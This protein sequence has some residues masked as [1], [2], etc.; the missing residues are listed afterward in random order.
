[1]AYLKH[2]QRHR[3]TQHMPGAYRIGSRATKRA[4]VLASHCSRSG[5][6]TVRLSRPKK[7]DGVIYDG[8]VL[9]KRRHD[10]TDHEYLSYQFGRPWIQPMM[11]K[12]RSMAS[13]TWTLVQGGAGTYHR[14]G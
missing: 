13:G 10:L 7:V 5:M 6:S 9:L 11:P 14:V 3:I 4:V 1:M 12:K 2:S 8:F